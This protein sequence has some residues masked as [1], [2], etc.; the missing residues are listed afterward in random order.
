MASFATT[1]SGGGGIA[2]RRGPAARQKKE[3]DL[4]AMV[5]EGQDGA[6]EALQLYRSRAMRFQTKNDIMNAIVSASHGS[7]VLLSK[8][9]I[10]A[11]FELASMT[12]DIINESGYEMNPQVRQIIFDID[13]AFGASQ[14]E[15]GAPPHPQKTEF[16][17]SCV[18]STI[19]N[20]QREYGE[21]Q[22]HNRLAHCLWATVPTTTTTQAKAY[23][24]AIYHFALGE[25]PIELVHHIDTTF[26]GKSVLERDRAFTLGVLNFLSFENLRDA[27]ELFKAFKKSCKSRNTS[28]DSDL[29][30]FCDYLLQTCRRDAAELFKKL[31]QSYSSHLAFDDMCQTLLQGP[32][33]TKV[34]NIPPKSNPMMSMLQNLLS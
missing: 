22:M 28:A 5:E 8:G 31:V 29:V 2:A 9:Y 11:G 27:N 23:T 24:S 10:T 14:K 30:N 16:L 26:G 17:K 32:I 7:V 25:E 21:P 20:G 18:K 1:A 19:A 34:F 13:N 6:Y 33:G 4:D 3:I 15:V 12:I